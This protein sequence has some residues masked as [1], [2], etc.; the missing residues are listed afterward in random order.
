MAFGSRGNLGCTSF[1]TTCSMSQQRKQTKLNVY[2]RYPARIIL[3]LPPGFPVKTENIFLFK[4]RDGSGADK[5][6]PVPIS[7]R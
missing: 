3:L 5:N 4:G 1:L 2:F 7:Y 6:L